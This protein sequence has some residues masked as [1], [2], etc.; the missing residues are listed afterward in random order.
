M[1]FLTEYKSFLINEEWS[2]NDPIPE[3]NTK[4]NL[5][6]ILLGP[7]GIGKS[8]F[9]KNFVLSRNQNIKTFSTDDVSLMFTKDPNVYHKGSS[10]LN[11]NR[12][13]KFMESGQSFI[14]DTT[15]T[16]EENIRDIHNVAKSNGYTTIFIHIIGPL[17]VSLKQNIGR[18]RQ[19]SPDYI[20]MAYD[21][22]FGNISKYSSE[23]HPDGY[24][25]VQNKDGKYKFSKYD[26]GKILKR[27][28]D[29][30]LAESK[31]SDVEV[32]F[33][34][35]ADSLQEYVDEGHRVVIYSANGFP[36]YVDSKEEDIKSFRTSLDYGDII[37]YKIQFRID[38]RPEVGYNRLIDILNDVKST[39]GRFASMGWFLKSMSIP[40]DTSETSEVKFTSAEFILS[41]SSEETENEWLGFDRLGI[42]AKRIERAFRDNGYSLSED[43]DYDDDERTII[44][45]YASNEMDGSFPPPR[46]LDKELNNICGTLG[47]EDFEYIDE[48]RVK[49]IWPS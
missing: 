27:K 35:I 8:T 42:T 17:D 10:Q 26:S 46:V 7:P 40:N 16:Q 19:V 3:L 28:A 20:K 39:I 6:I 21:K 23:L 34:D 22:Q 4:G 2:K 49:L 29:K 24:Y 13:K 32:G 18:E 31:G 41:K 15:G 11:I 33:W 43:P 37:K 5:G 45:Y 1:R 9:V 44:V 38:F 48:G 36:F 14:Y 47:A 12:L 30:Y 25:I